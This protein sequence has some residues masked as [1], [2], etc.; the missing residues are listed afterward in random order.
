ML[1][2]RRGAVDGFTVRDYV[3]G[4]RYDLSA[5]P[6]AVD[7]AQVFVREGWAVEVG[8]AEPAKAPEV[9]VPEAPLAEAPQAVDQPAA[10]DD[11]AAEP[12]K[13]KRKGR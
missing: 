6:G 1:S 5:T 7:L 8:A 4:E 11:A 13:A 2:H 12:A 10:G 9:I 3:E